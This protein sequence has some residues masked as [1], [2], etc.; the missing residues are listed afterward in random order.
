MP[1]L[2]VRVEQERGLL[3]RIQ[4]HVPGFAGYRRKEDIR[5]ADNML[6]IQMANMLQDTRRSVEDARESLAEN[7]VLEVMDKI[8]GLIS[9]FQTLEGKVRHAEGG[10]SG[11]SAAIRIQ[12][13]E[14]NH[15]YEYDTALL[16]T[17]VNM[18]MEAKSLRDSAIG[19]DG[20]PE[21]VNNLRNM[22]RDFEDNFE[23]RMNAITRTD[24]IR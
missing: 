23:A 16:D 17:C 6:R 14:L 4:L 18:D 24:V 2:R 3:K 12:E 13:D 5:T 10:Y 15:L 8:G 9:E 22:L 19:S 20:L 1:D 7:Y 11:I 21:K